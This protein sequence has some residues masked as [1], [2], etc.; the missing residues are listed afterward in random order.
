MKIIILLA[1][2]VVAL[3]A[4]NSTVLPICDIQVCFDQ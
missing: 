3:F 4:Y 2:Q 1:L